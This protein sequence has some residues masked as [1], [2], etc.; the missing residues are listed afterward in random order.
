MHLVH[1]IVERLLR[2]PV[3]LWC[4][5]L[6]PDAPA[7]GLAFPQ[8]ILSAERPNRLTEHQRATTGC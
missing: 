5:S 2:R 7:Q 6:R 1:Q 4:A 3:H 8:Q